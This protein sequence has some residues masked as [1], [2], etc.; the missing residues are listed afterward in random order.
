MIRGNVST[1][2][3]WLLSSGSTPPEK[4]HVIV[5]V[6]VAVTRHSNLTVSNLCAS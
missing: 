4:D 3:T 6:G 1:P 2:P 5:G